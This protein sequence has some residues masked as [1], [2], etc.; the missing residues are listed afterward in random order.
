MSK[1]KI[2]ITDSLFIFPEHEKA[3]TDAG[4]E[5]ERLDKATA[6]E[7]EL[8]KAVEGKVGYIMGGIEKVSDKVIEAGKDLKSIVFTGSDWRAFIPG[9]ESAT[10]RGILIANTPGANSF[11]VGEY[12]ITLMMAMMR[13]IFELGKTGTKKFQTTRS[14]NELTVGIIGMGKI[15]SK[16]ASD[17][18]NFGAKKVIYFSR[19]Q[20]PEIEKY[21]IEYLEMDEVLKQSDVIF[22]LIP[23]STGANFIGSKEFKL[24]KDKCLFVNIASRS[25]VD[26][27]ALLEELKSGR[28]SA[29]QDGPMDES[30]DILPLSV[31]FNS[32][33]STAYNTHSANKTASDMAV[34]SII[35]LIEKGEDKYKAN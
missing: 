18:K 20:K 34:S 17:M 14:L 5:I 32:N 19:S 6:T 21:G 30:F 4:Y 26:K 11:A 1:G 22:L 7:E 23:K 13:N 2:L 9:H 25:L 35:N 24:M 8:I 29:V 16:V 12:A 15:G 27:D 3:L 28:L 31:W 33:D 10:K